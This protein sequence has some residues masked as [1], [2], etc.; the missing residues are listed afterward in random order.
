MSVSAS[1]KVGLWVATYRLL[2]ISAFCRATSAAFWAALTA[3]S[4]RSRIF[5]DLNVKNLDELRDPLDD[6]TNTLFLY[7]PSILI[8][9]AAAAAAATSLVADRFHGSRHV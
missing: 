2:A 9:V 4:T 1:W 8:P 3:A 6:A 7:L 5:P